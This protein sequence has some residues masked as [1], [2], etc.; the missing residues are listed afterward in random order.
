MREVY[1]EQNGEKRNKRISGKGSTSSRMRVQV[2]LGFT[3]IFPS[4]TVTAVVETTR[5]DFNSRAIVP[6]LS[7]IPHK[8][9]LEDRQNYE[10]E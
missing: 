3:F 1:P 5:F 8:R 4:N 6:Y 10:T 2:V 9:T 7:T